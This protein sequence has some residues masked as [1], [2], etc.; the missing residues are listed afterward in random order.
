MIFG[1]GQELAVG[2]FL[3]RD[4]QQTTMYLDELLPN[5]LQLLK[6]TGYLYR[7]NATGFQKDKRLCDVEYISQKP[8]PV[9]AMEKIDNV[10]EKLQQAAVQIVTYENVP[11]EMKRRRLQKQPNSD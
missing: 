4:S 9:V 1:S 10:L 11:A 3:D 5:K 6:Q 8:T 2:Y 7:L